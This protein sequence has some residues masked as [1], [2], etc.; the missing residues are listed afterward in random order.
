MSSFGREAAVVNGALR[1]VRIGV[2]A[3]GVTKSFVMDEVA[4]VIVAAVAEVAIVVEVLTVAMVA[5]VAVDVEV[6]AVLV[7]STVNEELAGVAE[8]VVF[9]SAFIVAFLIL[10]EKIN[11]LNMITNSSVV[12]MSR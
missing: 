7:E 12:L 4:V 5:E 9:L 2:A 3:G 6:V 11:L 10:L 8:F 1:R